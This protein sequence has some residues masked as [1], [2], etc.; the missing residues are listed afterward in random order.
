MVVGEGGDTPPRSFIS[1]PPAPDCVWKGV[2]VYVCVLCA[3]ERERRT[4][5]RRLVCAYEH[6]K[7][8]LHHRHGDCSVKGNSF[9]KPCCVQEGRPFPP[10]GRRHQNKNMKRKIFA[11]KCPVDF[12]FCTESYFICSEYTYAYSY[13]IPSIEGALYNKIRDLKL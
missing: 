4:E 8:S 12:I 7:A 10:T 5:S 11:L 2:C 3:W 9:L 1:T 6:R 13:K